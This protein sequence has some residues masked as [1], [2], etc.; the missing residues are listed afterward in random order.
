MYC[1]VGLALAMTCLPLAGAIAADCESHGSATRVAVLELYTSE[2]CNSCP[3]A[4]RW[5]SSLRARGFNADRV[6]PLAFHVDYWDDLGWRDRFAQAAFSARQRAQADRRGARFVYTPQVLLN[7]ADFRQ[8]FLDSALAEQLARLNSQAA[9]AEMRLVQRVSAAGVSVDLESRVLEPP[10]RKFSETY[11]ALLENNLR[12]EVRA[13]EN[14]GKVLWH[15]FVVREIIGPLR[16]DAS[17]RLLWSGRFAFPGH[18]KRPD[19]AVAAFVQ[20][21]RDGDVLQALYAPLCGKP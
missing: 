6:L 13:G 18:W 16:A 17:G 2:G 5:V 8:T 9:A 14:S 3:P 15:D 20:D 7:G 1:A 19:L 10:A 12:S 4:D 21:S 11:V